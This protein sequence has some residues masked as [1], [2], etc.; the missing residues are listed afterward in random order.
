MRLKTIVK[1]GTALSVL[2]FCLA[3]GYYAFTQLGMTERYRDMNLFTLVP[4][5]C[6]GVMESDDIHTLFTDYSELSYGRELEKLHFPGL[7]HFILNGLSESIQGNAHGLSSQMSHMMVSFH[8]PGN[9]RDQ[10]VYFRMDTDDEHLLSDVLR[11]FM[12]VDFLP[13]EEEYRGEPIAIY[14]LGHE[15]FLASY[16]EDGFCVISFQ[17]R[18]IEKV[19]DARLNQ[20]SLND[21]EVFVKMLNRKKSHDFLTLYARSASMPFLNM[22]TDCWTEYDF[23]LNSDVLYMTGDTFSSE[24]SECF[25]HA[26]ELMEAEVNV[27]EDSLIVSSDKDSTNLYIEQ[28]YETLEGDG[29]TLFDEC[30]ANLSREASFS[31]VADME[32]VAEDPDLFERYLPPFIL[33]VAPKF[34]SFILSAQLSHNNGRLSHMWVFT[35]KD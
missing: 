22:E 13:R 7:Y 9:P 5:D 27:K 23:H 17:K 21:D 35:Y 4:S 1:L 24:Q 10:V 11:E 8:Q 30:V 16:S 28:A 25:P 34:R 20:T 26:L 32:K 33:H 15:E 31:L 3:V 2:L 29:L 19:I 14:P 12:P 18:L 6:M